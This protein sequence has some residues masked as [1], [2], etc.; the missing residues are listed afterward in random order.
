[1]R[2]CASNGEGENPR[3]MPNDVLIAEDEMLGAEPFIIRFHAACP[4]HT[5]EKRKR[6]EIYILSS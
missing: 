2:G 5:K 3:E 1:M 4:G 6:K